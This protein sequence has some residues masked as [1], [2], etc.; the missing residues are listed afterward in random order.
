MGG[1]GAVGRFKEVSK[2]AGLTDMDEET[3]GRLLEEEVLPNTC[4]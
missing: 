1:L 3:V 4:P 2:T